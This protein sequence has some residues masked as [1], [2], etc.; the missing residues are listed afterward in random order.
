MRFDASEVAAAGRIRSRAQSNR[1]G[2]LS[3]IG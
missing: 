2:L 3:L 1:G